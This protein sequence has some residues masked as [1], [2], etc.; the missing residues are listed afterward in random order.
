MKVVSILFLVYFFSCFL[1]SCD[2]QAST[3]R[4]T[5]QETIQEDEDLEVPEDETEDNWG[6]TLK[7]W[8]A[9]AWNKGAE[10]TETFKE[11]I[12]SIEINGFSIED[13]KKFG[14]ELYNEIQSDPAYNVLDRSKNEA[15]YAYIESIRDKILASGEFRYKTE[16]PWKI[17]ILK[18]KTINAFC[19][20]GGYIFI[21]TGILKF[22][23]NEAQFA[24]VLAH[25]M[26]HA[27]RRH[28][29]RQLTKHVGI[30]TVLDFLF[31]QQSGSVTKEVLSALTNL[32][33]SRHYE[34]EAD[35]YAVKF[36][37]S[38][39]YEASAGSGFFEKISKQDA[40]K[41]PELFST[42]PNP[43]ERIA[44]FKSRKQKLGCTG[45]LLNET[46]YKSVVNR[47]KP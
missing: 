13:D 4:D 14:Q 9:E 22:L 1:T 25:E 41:S 26:A 32:R 46:P 38:T 10:I 45:K 19:A 34:R 42:H 15:L 23:E 40:S 39:P 27:E 33:Y 29:T 6:E 21:Y 20:P 11:K 35:E 43:S 5:D 2:G 30:Q 24:G 12:K 37:C 17:T 44:N 3:N 36:L 7:S 18:D 28:S 31:G 8:G 47:I 16:F